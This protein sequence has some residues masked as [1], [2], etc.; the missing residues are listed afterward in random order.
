MA[1]CR[2]AMD[3]LAFGLLVLAVV[4]GTAGAAEPSRWPRY[5]LAIELDTAAH[6]CTTRQ[7]VTWTNRHR[8]PAAEL[9]FN[10]HAHYKLPENDVGMTAK[11]FEILRMTPRESLDEEGRALDVERVCLE[12]FAPAEEAGQARP[13]EAGQETLPAPRPLEPQPRELPFWY[14]DD[15]DS[16]LVV[17]LPRPVGPGET[18]TLTIDFTL[19]LP[20]KYGRW[21]YWKGITFL[22]NW[23]PV[24]AYYDEE[25]WHPT[26]YVVWHQPF[27]NEAAV[28]TARL[29]LPA[30]QKVACTA[31]VAAETD[32]GGGR[33]RIDFAPCQARDFA[34]L[35][36][37][38]Y[39]EHLARSGAVRVRCLAVAG[40]EHYGRV[41]AESAAEALDTFTR[42][43]GPYPYPEF[44]VVESYF[45][46]HSNEC[47]GLVMIDS[48]IFDMSHLARAF[49]DY[50]VAQ[51]TCHQWWYNV[52]GTNGYSETWMDE[53]LAT[54]F[55]YRL[56][57]AKYGHNDPLVQY[58][59][60]LQWLPNVNRND[61]RYF[62]LYGTL[63]RGEAQPTVQDIPKYGHIVDLYSMCYER[64]SKIVGMIEQQLG[65]ERF[66]DFMRGVYRRHAFAVLRV[67]DFQR[68]LEEYTRASWDEFFQKWVYGKGMTDWSID[69]V[70]VEPLADRPPGM[71]PAP[72]FQGSCLRKW[73][74]REGACKVTVVL[75]QKA[76]YNDP[77]VVGFCLDGGSGF[78]VRL[79]VAPETGLV[80]SDDPPAR[81]ET[82]AANRVRVE[83]VL[84]CEPTQ[85][86][87]DPDE[88]LVDRE[89][90]NNCW[91]PRCRVRFAPVYTFLDETDLT[92]AYDRWN[93]I[94][95]PWIFAPTFDNPWFTRSTR[96][97][98]R[99]G[100]Y[101]TQQ[102]EG[103]A[104]AAYRTDY[105]DFV[106]GIDG[107]RDHWPFDHTEVG[108]VFERRLAGTLRGEDA[109]NIGVLYG[110]YVIDYGDSL[111]LPPFQY[112]EAFTTVTDDLLPDARETVPGAIR[113]QHMATA[114]LHYHVNYLTPYW[115]PE[116]GFS[117]DLSYAAG[118]EVPGIHTDVDGS[119]QVL[120]Q[121][122]YVQSV[123]DGLGWLSLTRFAFRLYGAF[124]L[125]SN[126]QY[127]AL[128]GGELFRGFDLAQR[129]GSSL[130]VGSVEWRVPLALDL[131]WH[132]CDRAIGLENVYAALFSDVGNVYLKGQSVGGLAECAGVG[133]RLDVSWFTFVERTI[134]R[135]DV[136]RTIDS[137]APTQVWA[138]I[139]HPF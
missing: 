126:V 130:W 43:F 128:G 78:Q 135:L 124:G 5:D 100:A 111:Y 87:V 75:R 112:V 88:V 11:I 97:G 23:L 52:V 41:M 1:K 136:A 24:L 26:P 103:G 19:R 64:G 34:V 71:A 62:N 134:I 7:R 117:A 31:P 29:T 22:T 118:L 27:F 59:Q 16:A 33:R 12:S 9:V 99:A 92:N 8:R 94:F 114:G 48:R 65:E 121:A 49:V 77:T 40:H 107:I 14:R 32:V 4:P 53:G 90:D 98:V 132:F 91:K 102:F 35:C 67:A 66:F 106:M 37:A 116:G 47:A 96:F 17:S 81:I 55:A 68:D 119:D 2:A 137:A 127:F 74:H 25:G 50:L 58:P 101:R 109:A 42:W 120:G 76:E 73:L 82:L 104:Y 54:Y 86:A 85:I 63:A 69:S 60:G 36:C 13:G 15:N 115:D 133:L 61:Y 6:L 46:W 129:Q 45:G 80:E 10:A 110:R 93:L 89:P 3:R 108:F 21:G 44:T 138:G 39:V 38:R 95:G 56:M 139:E 70:K 105:R 84:P 72:P 30:D 122:T 51:S 18:V 28:F 57:H 125:P 79:P 123:P 20:E 83:V 113:F 131:H